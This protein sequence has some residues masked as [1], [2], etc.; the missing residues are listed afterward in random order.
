[1][2]DYSIVNITNPNPIN[3]TNDTIDVTNGTYVNLTASDTVKK[4]LMPGKIV[5][6]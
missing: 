6:V 3:G 5:P 2:D 1:M 4:H